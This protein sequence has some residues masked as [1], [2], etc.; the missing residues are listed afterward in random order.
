MKNESPRAE[1]SLTCGVLSHDGAQRNPGR[2]RVLGKV[3]R[4]SALLA[5]GAIG[6]AAGCSGD[7]ANPGSTAGAAGSGGAGGSGGSGGAGGMC[8]AT[9]TACI[10][11]TDPM[12]TYV[13]NMVKEG[14]NKAF[15]FQL[16]QSTPA[17]PIKGDNTWKIKITDMA[18]MP[19]NKG[20]T[21]RVWMPMHRHDSLTPPVV[22]YDEAT[23]TYSFKPIDLGAMGGIWQ[24]II[25]V[26]DPSN[27]GVPVDSAT[28]NFCVE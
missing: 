20:L 17:P 11:Q 22:T 12:D 7:D 21:L 9:S 15:S 10:C 14:T 1:S 28:F 4:F 16:V 24:V 6:F 8:N 13:A 26:N 3:A 27:P 5:L 18:G 23:S 2:K 25:T 19:V